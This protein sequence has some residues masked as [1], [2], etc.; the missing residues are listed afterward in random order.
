MNPVLTARNL[1]PHR[2]RM[3]LV[4]DIIAVDDQK[5]VTRSVAADTWPLFDGD[6]VHPIILIELVAQTA[7]IH[8]GWVREKKEGPGIDKSGWVVGVKHARLPCRG[9][10]LKTEFVTRSENR[11]EFEGFREILGTVTVEDKIV[12]EITLQLLRSVNL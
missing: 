3:L 12:T 9:F 8:N 6:C 10:A 11:F 2:G 4:G 7:G 1:L 5:A